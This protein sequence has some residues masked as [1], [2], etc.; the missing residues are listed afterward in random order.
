MILYYTDLES[1][2]VSAGANVYGK[3]TMKVDDFEARVDSG[4]RLELMLDANE[5]EVDVNSGGNFTA[6]GTANKLEVDANSGGYF[7]GKKLEVAHVDA[8]ANS[9]LLYTSPS[10]RDKRQSRMPSSA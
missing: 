6:E 2:D 5:I 9:C 1:I 7:K 3:E 4:G 10:P 8:H